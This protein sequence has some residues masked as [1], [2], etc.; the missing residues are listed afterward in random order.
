[1]TWLHTNGSMTDRGP[2][3]VYWDE[4]ALTAKR[5]HCGERMHDKALGRS[6]TAARMASTSRDR[7]V[8]VRSPSTGTGGKAHPHHQHPTPRAPRTWRQGHGRGFWP[9]SRRQLRRREHTP[10]FDGFY[11]TRHAVWHAGK[12]VEAGGRPYHVEI[13]TPPWCRITPRLPGAVTRL[14]AGA[15]GW[16]RTARMGPWC[17]VSARGPNN[18]PNAVHVNIALRLTL[19]P[20]V[21]L[22]VIRVVGRRIV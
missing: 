16:P 15:I 12:K 20:C 5:H 7:W 8:Q 3:R 9:E 10:A 14:C 19:C 11:C 4:G 22:S 2:H 21:R 18:V 6:P 1:V 17:F 13:S